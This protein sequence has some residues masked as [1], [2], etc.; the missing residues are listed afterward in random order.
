MERRALGL[1]AALLLLA[2]CTTVVEAEPVV[3]ERLPNPSIYSA[4]ANME[5]LVYRAT[6]VTYRIKCFGSSGTGI[7]VTSTRNGVTSSFIVTNHHVIADCLDGKEVTVTDNYSYQ[8][9]A[10]VI[11]SKLTEGRYETR[12]KAQDIALLKPN[13]ETFQTIDD[14]SYANP[15]GSWVMVAGYP[16]VSD[17]GPSLVVTTGIIS[18]KIEPFGFLTTAAINPGSSGSMVMNSRGEVIGFVYAGHD[19]N[20][21]NDAGMFLPLSRLAELLNEIQDQ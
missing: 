7:G 17:A 2:G 19:E 20:V 12:T 15:I 8:F 13:T 4:P 16:R 10:E 14:Y 18:S 11:A 5:D 3:V 9:T 6:Q 21:L 1:A